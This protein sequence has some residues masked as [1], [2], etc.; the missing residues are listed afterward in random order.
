MRSMG[1]PGWLQS[2]AA[3]NSARNGDRL[4]GHAHTGNT[5]FCQNGNSTLV[6]SAAAEDKALSVLRPPRQ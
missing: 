1:R 3:Y 6:R 4:P 2:G 5:R